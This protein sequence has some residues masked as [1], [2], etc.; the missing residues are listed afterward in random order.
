MLLPP[1]RANIFKPGSRGD[2]FI[3]DESSTEM[4]TVP[5]LIIFNPSDSHLIQRITVIVTTTRRN[6]NYSNQIIS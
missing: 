3:S 5:F 4:I 6:F 1:E 2:T